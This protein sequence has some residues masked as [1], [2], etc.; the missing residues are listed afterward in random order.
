V[1]PIPL[2]AALFVVLTAFEGVLQ[3]LTRIRRRW[4]VRGKAAGSRTRGRFM[5]AKRLAGLAL[6]VLLADS[7]LYHTHYGEPYGKVQVE[8]IQPVPIAIAVL[9]L[10]A[11]V[12]ETS[13]FGFFVCRADADRLS[14]LQRQTYFSILSA[15]RDGVYRPLSNESI[16]LDD[17][18]VPEEYQVVAFPGPDTEN[19]WTAEG[20]TGWEDDFECDVAAVNRVASPTNVTSTAAP[21]RLPR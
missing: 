15:S 11:V 12:N 9:L 20:H 17:A 4:R 14:P 10:L 2:A 13:V 16:E 7:V 5:V 21:R 6:A 18:G 3:G 8:G 1:Y 19:E